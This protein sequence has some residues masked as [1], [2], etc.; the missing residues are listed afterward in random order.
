MTENGGESSE[1]VP[2]PGPWPG[3][4]ESAQAQWSTPGEPGGPSWG[5]SSDGPTTYVSD[6]A[7]SGIERPEIVI[8][9]ALV[10]GL[11]LAMLLRRLAR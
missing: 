8:G 5:S 3:Q 7:P 2:P 10:G 6:T 9:A 11:L 4:T 1:R